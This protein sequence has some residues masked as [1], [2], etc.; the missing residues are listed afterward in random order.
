MKTLNINLEDHD[1]NRIKFL[2]SKM[3]N[4]KEDITETG[5]IILTSMRRHKNER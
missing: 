5:D 3:I 1:Y 2:A 4:S